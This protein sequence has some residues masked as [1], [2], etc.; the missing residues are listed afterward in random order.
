[1]NP[2]FLSGVP[3]SYNKKFE[4]LKCQGVEIKGLKTSVAPR[5]THVNLQSQESIA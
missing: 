1:M 4:T 2:I 5:R 3:V